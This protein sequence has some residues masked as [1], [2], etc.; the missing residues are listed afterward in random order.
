MRQRTRPTCG[1]PGPSGMSVVVLVL[2]VADD[3]AGLEQGV[4]VVAAQALLPKS[5][6]ERV[7]VAVVPRAARRDENQPGLV[8]AES[9]QRMRN[10]LRTVVQAQRPGRA[11][12]RGDTFF[13]SS[14]RRSPV[15][16]RSTRF[17]SD[18]RVCSS[19][20]DAILMALP[21]MVGRTGSRSPTP[22]S[23]HRRGSAPSRRPPPACVRR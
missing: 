21:S 7:D 23:A 18:S 11:A 4:P 20:I 17:S 1:S 2:E 14:T 3:H 15:I 16:E 19:I 13:S 12:G 5:A 22:P 9:L 10:H 8:L 6:V